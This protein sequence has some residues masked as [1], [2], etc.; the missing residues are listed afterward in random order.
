MKRPIITPFLI[1]NPIVIVLGVFYVNKLANREGMAAM[2]V[3]YLT[4]PMLASFLLLLADRFIIDEDNRKTIVI[5]ESVI[6]GL[7]VLVVSF[8]L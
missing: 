7:S 3:N 4:I 8:Y 5:V 2:F 1:V 6:I